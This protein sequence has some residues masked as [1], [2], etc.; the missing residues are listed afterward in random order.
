MERCLRNRLKW[1]LP[2]LS[3]P[4][5]SRSGSFLG[6]RS[7]RGGI[8][9]EK[10]APTEAIGSTLEGSR[11]EKKEISAQATLKAVIFRWPSMATRR[12][13]GEAIRKS[14]VNNATD[15]TKDDATSEVRTRCSH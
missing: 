9:D 10:A 12:M 2:G 1:A 4:E 3:A 5:R 11:E 8:E 15:D 7:R 13:S 14:S 6:R